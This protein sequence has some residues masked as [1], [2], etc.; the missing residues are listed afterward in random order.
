MLFVG[1]YTHR[2]AQGIYAWRFDS[3][4]GRA[5][6]LGLVA[7]TENPSFLAL[8]PSGRYL[9]AVNELGR[10][11]G[12]QGGAVS[13]FGVDA[14]TGHLTPLNQ[15]ASGGA[16]P[17]FITVDAGGKHALVANYTG[18]SVEVLPIA[19]DGHLGKASALLS[20]HG[21]GVNPARQEAPHAHAVNLSPDGRFALVSDL[22]M[23][24]IRSF[25]FDAKRGSLAPG[26][27][28]F[29]RSAPSAGP[30]HLAFHPNGHRIYVFNEL[31]SS[32]TTYEYTPETGALLEVQTVSTLPAEFK[33]SNTGAEIRVHP[34]GRF[35]YASNRGH[36]SIAV[37]SIDARTGLLNLIQHIPSGGRTPRSIALDPSG[38]WL[39]AAHQ[40]TNNIA[41]FKIDAASGRL[42]ATEGQE[43]KAPS[44]VCLEFR[45]SQE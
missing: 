11:R 13:A 5:E 32:V 41:V 10:F 43:F 39:L 42:S 12:Q 34:S 27:P 14:A 21:V 35:V 38:K 9:F 17:C 16:D 36:D 22:G 45:R 2:D 24:L 23:D 20:F 33:G 18:G 19:A 7:K 4:T 37:F 40:D 15:V 26:E 6:G 8:H 30:R 1:T 3:G 29:A 44:P 28:P 31:Q 25:R